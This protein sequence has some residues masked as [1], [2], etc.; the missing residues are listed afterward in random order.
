MEWSSHFLH[1]SLSSLYIESV[2]MCVPRLPST[3][4]SC[5]ECF[6]LDPVRVHGP[7]TKHTKH[8]RQVDGNPGSSPSNKYESVAKSNLHA[9][10]VEAIGHGTH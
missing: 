9:Q 7:K 6:V 4:V 2:E 8:V 10:E 1:L 5:F 3:C